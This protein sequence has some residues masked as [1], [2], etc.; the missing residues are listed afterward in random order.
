MKLL[1]DEEVGAVRDVR[2]IKEK[3]IAPTFER[4]LRSITKVLSIKS[5]ANMRE[6]RKK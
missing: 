6:R 3:A 1:V 4:D 2:G 5:E